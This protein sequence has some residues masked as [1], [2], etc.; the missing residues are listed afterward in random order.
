MNDYKIITLVREPIDRVL[1]SW[2]WFSL[3][4]ET[5]KKHKWQSIDDMLDEYE[6]GESRVNYMPQT[7]WLCEPG[8]R[9]DH[10]CRFEDLLKGPGKIQKVFPDYKPK[11]K[12]RR[13]VNDLKI[14][15]KQISRIKELYKADIDFLAEYYD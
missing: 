5:A 13:T 15:D 10:S 9:F 12:L 1:S 8:A 11:G 7:R 2:K 6:S 14:T 3:V 4:K